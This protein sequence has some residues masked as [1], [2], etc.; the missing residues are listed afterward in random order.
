MSQLSGRVREH[1]AEGVTFLKW[2]LYSCLVGVIVGLVAVAFHVGIDMVTEL[3]E[4]HPR[5]I[6]LLPLTGPAIVLLYRWCG[7]EKDQGTNLVLVAVRDAKRLKL[8]TAPLIFLSTICT[9]LAG[10]S[11]GRE[12]AALQLGEFGCRKGLLENIVYL[13]LPLVQRAVF[14]GSWNEIKKQK[15]WRNDT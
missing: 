2:L 11:A 14:D 4:Q 6:W 1:L 5:I 9:H 10:G 3:R 7:M 13:G 15:I 8:R 12:G